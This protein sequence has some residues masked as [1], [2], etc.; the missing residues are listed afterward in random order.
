M[1]SA[2]DKY[3]RTISYSAVICLLI[4]ALVICP[5]AFPILWQ[6]FAYYECSLYSLIDLL[7]T[8]P[9]IVPMRSEELPLGS[10]LSHAADVSML[11][12]RFRFLSGPDVIVIFFDKNGKE[13][14]KQKVAVLRFDKAIWHGQ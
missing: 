4:L 2:R 11:Q 9:E 12:K 3:H 6:L 14:S 5:I 7:R 1:G 10:V 8:N 13:I